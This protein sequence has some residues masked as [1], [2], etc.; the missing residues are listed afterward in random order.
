[1]TKELDRI[2]E[3]F[4][5]HREK[6]IELY[7]SNPNF[8]SLCDDYWISVQALRVHRKNL[9][10]DLILTEEYDNICNLLEKEV[11]DYLQENHSNP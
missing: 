4:P 1:M 9:K 6:I 3:K 5:T 7:N 2:L 10:S 8:R 11:R